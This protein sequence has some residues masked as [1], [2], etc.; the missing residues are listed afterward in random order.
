MN[1]VL[2]VEY[3]NVQYSIDIPDDETIGDLRK[4][5]G[6]ELKLADGT[7]NLSLKDQPDF[8]FDDDDYL[9][10][11]EKIED[12]CTIS[13]EPIIFNLVITFGT[14]KFQKSY[15]PNIEISQILDDSTAHFNLDKAKSSLSFKNRKLNTGVT[16]MQAELDLNSELILTEESPSPSP[17]PDQGEKRKR[18]PTPKEETIQV[19]YVFAKSP[20]PVSI[21][22]SS[23]TRRC[24]IYKIIQSPPEG[25]DKT[26]EENIKN[27][28]DFWGVSVEMHPITAN[29]T[30]TLKSVA[31]KHN[32]KI[33]KVQ[34]T[35]NNKNGK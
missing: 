10:Y 19:Q 20:K 24:D 23:D 34:I 1:L 22:Y 16:I 8:V 29:S 32:T 4:K 3:Q 14:Q 7:F 30:E 2:N 18:K 17:V 13:V 33:I 12:D 31:Q 21:N 28:G 11:C 15:L 5:I 26:L 25:I 27:K 9:G 6:K 35:D